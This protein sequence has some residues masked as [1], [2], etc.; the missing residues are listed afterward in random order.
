MKN[1]FIVTILLLFSLPL[2]SQDFTNTEGDLQYEYHA[3]SLYHSYKFE[4]AITLYHKALQSSTDSLRISG[5]EK[6]LLNCENGINM[7]QYIIRP[8]LLNSKKLSLEDFYLYIPDY[9]D[10]C[11][12]PLPNPFNKSA[13]IHQFYSAIHFTGNSD[14]VIFS[15]PDESGAW[16]IYSS[17]KI[18]G[19]N[20]SAPEILSEATTSSADEI[21]PFLSPDGKTLYFASNGFA[22]IGGFDL[23]KSEW[24]NES[25][26]WGIPENLGF[27]YS[28]THNDLIYHNT[29]DGNF[30]ILFSDRNSSEGEIE[31]FVLEA[32]ATP[33][34]TAL[35]T[36]ESAEDIARFAIRRVPQQTDIDQTTE[37]HIDSTLQH[38]YDN[39]S[40]HISKIKSLQQDYRE[41]REKLAE[42][43][44][45]YQR[46]NE[47]DKEFLK[48]IIRDLEEEAATIKKELEQIS[49]EV[50][51]LEMEFL[52]KGV[53]PQKIEDEDIKVS[54]NFQAP[55][56]KFEKR[57]M[58]EIPYIT[59][60]IPEPKFDY[61][62]KVLKEGQFAPDNSLPDGLVYQI[63]IAVLG[64][65]A[66]AK[67]LKGLSPVFVK[68]LNSGKYLHTVG[69]FRT[70]SEAL[71]N[72][73]TVRKK[74]FSSAFIIA[75]NDGQS[76]TIKK[77]K[78]IEQNKGKNKGY[79]VILD[80]YQDGLPSSVL[81]II[82]QTS[83][84]DISRGTQNGQTIYMVGPFTKKDEAEYLIK[85][86]KDLGV[87]NVTL[88]TL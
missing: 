53:I 48:G 37:F 83:D 23:F 17:V 30:T 19:N 76:I 16:N 79:S 40:I 36:D 73:N 45:M 26:E 70:H 88:S 38:T 54:T 11:W 7:L 86:L 43:R 74:G 65:K 84:K 59:V 25:G 57:E 51:K 8:N 75:Y 50:H 81:T 63:Q 14:K 58:G 6:K 27:P 24:D 13:T 41:K 67:D 46:A 10:N 31:A 28:S 71:S 42:S 1:L 78:S 82:Q 72:L 22:G 15:A 32:I 49:K 64:S 2:V 21:F 52:S 77:A 80:G 87:E 34:K 66:K 3:D 47:S 9:E 20:W 61:S 44:Q 55:S 33:V 12:I 69:V 68:K 56:F 35:R 39:Y 18:A 60:E 85:T 29:Y 4:K 5:I 62:F